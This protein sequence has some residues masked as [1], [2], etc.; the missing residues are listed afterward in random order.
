MTIEITPASLAHVT[1]GRGGSFVTIEDDVLDIAKQIQEVHPEFELQYNE[2]GEYFRV[3]QATP[4]YRKHT[5]TTA[6]EADTRLVNRLKALVA[7]PEAN[8][9]SQVEND[10]RVEANQDHR[11]SEAVG[12]ASERLAFAIRSELKK[13]RPGNVYIPPDMYQQNK[14]YMKGK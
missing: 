3:V 4:G 10:R 2:E 5:V 14:F 12:E 6:L 11:F 13:G 8:R 7:D 1:K 9:Q